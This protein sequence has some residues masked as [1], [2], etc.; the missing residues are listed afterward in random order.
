[1]SEN[2][3]AVHID[4][5]RSEQQRNVMRRIAEDGVDPF[6]WEQLPKYHEQPILK[7]GRYWLVTPNDSPYEG[8]TLHLLLIYRDRIHSFA[9]MPPSG[10]LELQVLIQWIQNEY[11]L[12]YGAL[13]MR[14]GEL[15]LSGASVD[16]PH[17][18]IITGGDSIESEKLKVSIGYK[19]K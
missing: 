15:S 10:W 16:H 11:E 7:K 5:G 19:Q 12:K 6:D 13:V 8:S 18:H 9:E 4:H 2:R 14:F 1:M 17:M 3:P